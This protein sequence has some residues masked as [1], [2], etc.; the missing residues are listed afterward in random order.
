MTAVARPA[1]PGARAVLQRY[2][3]E[4]FAWR[5]VSRGRLDSSSRVSF[6]LPSARVARYRVVVRGGHGWADG[7]SGNIV[8]G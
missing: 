2:V 1:R 6:H 7:A 5:T 4:H 3:R 8:R